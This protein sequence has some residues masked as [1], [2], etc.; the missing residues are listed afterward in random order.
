MFATCAANALTADPILSIP[1]SPRSTP[2]QSCY[3][4]QSVLKLQISPP[5]SVPSD[6]I[7]VQEV[8]FS[9]GGRT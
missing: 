5:A 3:I 9:E 8:S 4:A 1:L 7:I 6:V 2:R